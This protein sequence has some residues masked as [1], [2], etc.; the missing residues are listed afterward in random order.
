LTVFAFDATTGAPK[1]ADA[2]N[3]TAYVNKDDAGINALADTSA[4]EV[5]STNAAGY[6]TFDLAQAETNADK[7]HFTAKSGTAD[8]VVIAVPAVVQT[9]PAN[10]TSATLG[11]LD[12]AVSTRST[13][14]GGAV[15][16]VTGAVTVGTI[17]SGVITAASIAANAI[18]AAKI[19]ADAI[20][21][22]QSGLSTA[23]ALALVKAILDKLDTAMEADGGFYRF[24]ANALEQAPTGSGG[25]STVT[26]PDGVVSVATSTT[27]FT[28]TGANLN[29]VSGAYN[30]MFI[31]FN[32]DSS[33]GNVKGERRQIRTHTVSGSNHTFAFASSQAWTAA[34]GVG[35]E[36]VVC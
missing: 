32:E 22:I 8:I 30:G 26:F 15:A 20:T 5:S 14:A 2:A 21:A 27:Q 35:A 6:Y 29:A 33:G 13:Y 9:V 17:N 3:I 10:L 36:F 1:P 18:A 19:A 31:R 24:T 12:A 4:T 34:P 11:N 7:L 25:A 16:S 28:A 23:A